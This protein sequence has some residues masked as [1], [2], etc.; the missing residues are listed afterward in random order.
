M[1]GAFTDDFEGLFQDT[2]SAKGNLPS[3]HPGRPARR[4]G[5]QYHQTSA[6]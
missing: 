1:T 3:R 2:F 6:L 5:Q 4:A